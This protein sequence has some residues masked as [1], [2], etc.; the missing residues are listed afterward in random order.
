MGE[1]RP[2]FQAHLFKWCHLWIPW[3][4]GDQISYLVS[5]GLEKEN[6][7][8]SFWSSYQDGYLAHIGHLCLGFIWLPRFLR[9]AMQDHHGLLVFVFLYSCCRQA[10]SC[11]IW[12]TE[13]T[14]FSGCWKASQQ[15]PWLSDWRKKNGAKKSLIYNP[16]QVLPHFWLR[17]EHHIQQIS[18]A[19]VKRKAKAV[20]TYHTV[21]FLLS[22]IEQKC[23]YL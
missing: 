15:P 18:P 16:I 4:S 6:L 17:P 20:G 2:L 23:K 13:R 7:F 19:C 22:V 8:K 9:G 1:F 10:N 11:F 14:E 21:D 3:A 5:L 12:T